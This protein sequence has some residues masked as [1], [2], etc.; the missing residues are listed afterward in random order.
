MV[1]EGVIVTG[2]KSGIGKQ[3]AI[4]LSAAGYQVVGLDR[5]AEGAAL[6]WPVVACDLADPSS[7]EEAFRQV[8]AE[9]GVPYGLVNNA[10]A[11]FAKN[12]AEQSLQEFD[13]TLA[14]NARAPFLLSR[15]FAKAVMD[16]GRQGV[17]VNISSV[18][19]TIGS[20]DVAYAASKAALTAVSKSLAKAFAASGVRVVTVSPGPVET[21]MAARIPEERKKAYREG[22]PLKR[23]A[24]PKEISRTVVFLL[25]KDASYITGTDIRVDGG[26]V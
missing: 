12:W 6:S 22:I 11:Y 8:I 19:A 5:N 9:H 25:S 24:D 4:D 17:I 2:S 15:C 21:R 7:V 3:L 20:V 26:L 13:Y 1:K 14:V 10:G 18:S 23:F 16:A